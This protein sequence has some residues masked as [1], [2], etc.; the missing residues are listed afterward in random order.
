M[1]YDEGLA[2][3]VREL[4]GG[5]DGVT[6]RKM[7]GGIAW[8][9]QGNMACGVLGEELLVRLSHEDAAAALREP[10]VREFDFTGRVARGMAVVDGAVVEDDSAL[11]SW[12]DAGANH[13]SSLEPK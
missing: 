2:A 4:L 11:G 7:F 13:A 5:R 1:A 10:G 8:M 9:I 3:R 12:V 6:E